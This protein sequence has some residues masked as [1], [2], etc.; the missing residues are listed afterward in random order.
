MILYHLAVMHKMKSISKSR[1]FKIGSSL[2]IAITGFSLLFWI[3][4][5]SYHEDG[6][7]YLSAIEAILIFT[8]SGFDSDPPHTLL[9]WVFAVTSLLFGI[10]FVGAFTAEIA[11]IFVE[12]RMKRFS[13]VK[14]VVFS[15]HII[16]CGHLSDAEYF[17]EQLFH[18]DHGETNLKVVFLMPDPPSPLIEGLLRR[19]KFKRRIKYIIGTPLFKRDL[20]RANASFAKAAFIF[21]NRFAED[22][23]QEDAKTILRTLAIQ[24]YNKEIST[25]VQVLKTKNKGHIK[26]TGTHNFMCIDELS[27]NIVAQ[28]CINPGLTDL[29]AN[30]V[31]SSDDEPEDD[32]PKW[33]QERIT[34]AGREVYRVPAGLACFMLPFSEVAAKVHAKFDV[35]IIGM[36]KLGDDEVYRFAV[37]PGKEWDVDPGDYLYIIADD[38]D[39]AIKVTKQES[40]MRLPRFKMPPKVEQEHDESGWKGKVIPYKEARLTK[41]S[42]ENHIVICGANKNLPL[43]VS[44]LRS[45]DLLNYQRIVVLHDQ[46]LPKKTLAEMADFNEVYYVKGSPLDYEDLAKTNI[47]KAAKALILNNKTALTGDEIMMDA[48]TVMTV[49]GIEH[50]GED[51]YTIAEVVYASN[52]SFLKAINEDDVRHF[53]VNETVTMSRIADSLVCQSFYT[54]HFMDVFDELFSVDTH[55]EDEGRNTCEIYQIPVPEFFHGKTYE[56]FFQFLAFHHDVIPVGLYRI[57]EDDREKTYVFTAPPKETLL[58]GDDKVYVFAA[59]EPEF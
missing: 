37:N 31:N 59:D 36:E 54:P 20:E 11:S 21:A 28:S 43:L 9:G 44:P 51:V 24:S 18:P 30:L 7:S 25:Y 47:K 14:R 16:V 56:Q 12:S 39:E 5:H 13:D 45:P 6:F 4:E 8:L 35:T 38:F 46:P 57:R 26:S 58:K 3:V 41:I 29:I 55:D 49:M 27:L 2:F 34:G 32:Q 22:P 15:E 17:F 48:D 1:L 50:L 33:L 42:F 40:D 52:T 10:M 23:D 53:T 19:S